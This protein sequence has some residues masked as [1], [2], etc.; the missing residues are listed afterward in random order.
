MGD[1]YFYYNNAQ[2]GLA[3]ASRNGLKNIL[4]FEEIRLMSG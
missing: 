4:I 3:E 2:A 1:G